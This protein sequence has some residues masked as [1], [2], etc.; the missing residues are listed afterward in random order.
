[1]EGVSCR[2]TLFALFLVTDPWYPGV[3]GSSIWI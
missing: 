2:Y 3:I 1:M